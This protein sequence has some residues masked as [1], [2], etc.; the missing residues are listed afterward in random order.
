MYD[1]G[2]SHSSIDHKL[3]LKRAVL[4]QD[5]CVT[6]NP[7]AV[8]SIIHISIHFKLVGYFPISS[9]V[10]DRDHSFAFW[11]N[12][13]QYRHEKAIGGEVESFGR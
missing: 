8:S 2:A 7:L 4:D 12:P 6:H 9:G 13:L 1:L 3:R 5:R 11:A 10:V